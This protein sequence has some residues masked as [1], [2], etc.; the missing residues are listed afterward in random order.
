MGEMNAW[1]RGHFARLRRTPGADLLS[2]MITAAAADADPLS[3]I[4][5]VSIAGLVLAAG[6]E[7]T[8]NLLGNGA[9]L[10][11]AHPEQ[12]AGLRAEPAGWRNAVEEIL[13][14]DSPAQN[15]VRHTVRDVTIAGVPVPKGKF[16][17]LVLAG[18]NRDPAVFDDPDSFDVRR[19]NARE[20]ISF[21]AGSHYCLGAALSRMEG[22]IGLRMLF[23]R[24]PDLRQLHPGTRRPAR[25][26]RG[27]SHLPVEVGR[28]VLA[29]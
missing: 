5:L 18:A 17:A 14:Y 28:T 1:F 4:D 19:A 11:F 12:L 27:Y 16:I 21:G 13:R 29:G 8:V 3:D 2:S 15:T 26:L 10:L 22:E 9:A 7:T 20:H 6:F 24:F 25:I 23:E